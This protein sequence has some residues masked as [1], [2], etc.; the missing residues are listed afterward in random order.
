[1]PTIG[2]DM[3]RPYR[4]T[5]RVRESV[6]PS[7]FL[8][9][10][11]SHDDD[12]PLALRSRETE[13]FK[14]PVERIERIEPYKHRPP[15]QPIRNTAH[16]IIG[17]SAPVI[18]TG[19]SLLKGT[20]AVLGPSLNRDTT[21]HLQLDIE[22]DLESCLEEFSRLKRLGNYRGAE[23]YFQGN[24]QKFIDIPPVSVELADMLLTQG[25]YKRLKELRQEN[26]LKPP[27]SQDDVSVRVSKSKKS[28]NNAPKLVDDSNSDS[29][30]WSDMSHYDGGIDE[31]K[32][33]DGDADRFDITFR[34][35][36]TASYMF[37][38]GWLNRALKTAMKTKCGLAPN[39][40][41]VRE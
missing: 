28:R 40:T 6:Q 38:Q 30:S 31:V 36:E 16:I 35:I 12:R 34:L 1:M 25:A 26:K 4:T 3:P 33:S 37:S 5:E 39:S 23:E 24:L 21:I 22:E 20:Q 27:P 32:Q 2:I 17:E 8:R 7:D 11:Y 9:E 19:P 15:P 10:I 41:S 14:R 13:T 18:P 29:D